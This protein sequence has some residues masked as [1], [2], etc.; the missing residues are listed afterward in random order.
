MRICL[1]LLTLL[2][3]PFLLSAQEV[4]SG[5]INEYAAV[6]ELDSC[7]N[8]LTLDDAS[9]FQE[10]MPVLLMQMQGAT[11]STVNNAEFGRV[12]DP[13]GAGWYER[14]EIVSIAGNVVTLGNQLIH[15][16]DPAGKLQL[17]SIP[18]YE[19]AFVD[20]LLTA[21]PWNGQTGGVLILEVNNMLIL[22]SNIDVSGLGFRGGSADVIPENNCAFT[23]NANNYGYSPTDWRGAH[24]GE[25]IG[26]VPIHQSTG[27]GA[28]AN[29]GGGGNDHNSGG[30]GGSQI[31]MGGQGG[32]NREPTFFG[33]DGLYPG[34]GGKALSDL[35][36]RFFMGG[37]GGAGHENNN[38]STAGG[39]GGGIAII[40]AKEYLGNG[41]MVKANGID[42][43]DTAGDGAGGGGGAG[44]VVLL[45]ET[46]L[47]LHLEA[48]GGNGGFI[49]NGNANRCIGPGGGGGGGRIL[50]NLPLL[51]PIITFLPGTAGMSINSS[52]S[53]CPDGTNNAQNGAAGGFEILDSL[54]SGRQS[55]LQPAILDQPTAI[56]ACTDDS[57]GIAIEMQGLYLNFQWQ[58]DTGSGFAALVS[59]P[60]YSGTQ[61]PSLI[62][63]PI[64]E[65]FHNN[66]YR[67]FI[68][69]NC[70]MD[71]LIS[72]PIL[73]EV[74]PQPEPDFSF[75]INGNE[76]QFTNNSQNAT[77]YLW[78]FG[79]SQQTTEVNPL[80]TY[81][82]P[83]TY[84]VSLSATNACGTE[85]I[86]IP[87]VL[88]EMSAPTAAFTAN[89]TA[90]CLPL[91]VQFTSQSTG[92]PTGY[93]WLFP[94]GS[95]A[96]SSME[97]PIVT[98]NNTGTY[99]ATLIVT[100]AQG[101]DSLILTDFIEVNDL[102]SGAFSY[103]LNALQANFTN[104]SVNA[105]S[106]QWLFG[107]SQEST[108]ESPSHTYTM[109][110][111]YEVTLLAT[112]ACGTSTQVQTI[113]IGMAPQAAFTAAPE[114]GCVPRAIL[115]TNTSTGTFDSQTWSFPGGD[116]ATSTAAS[117]MVTYNT[118]GLY[119]VTLEL[120]SP[121]GPTTLTQTEAIEILPVPQPD[122]NF[123][124]D[125][126]TVTFNNLSVD[127]TF[128]SWNFGDDNTSNQTNPTYTYTQPGTYEVSL[129]AQNAYCGVSSSQTIF[130]TTSTEELISGGWQVF[131]NP[132][133]NELKLEYNY[134]HFNCQLYTLQGQLVREGSFIGQGL[135]PTTTLP[136]GVYVLRMFGETE[137]V[138]KVVR[139]ARE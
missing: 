15:P 20:A 47:G 53:G 86:D 85:T 56:T 101:V 54:L 28:Q 26:I 44:T 96:F 107:D 55:A 79:D 106:Y 105:D 83:G 92:V 22:D 125:G 130:L 5:I 39:R 120:S 67:L 43:N 9:V 136:A 134:G 49:N 109:P 7:T 137:V 63:N 66:R 12:L 32:E 127:A 73:L 75:V 128:F 117:V 14:N 17:I 133:E 29:G 57:L 60:P 36:E 89:P 23:T 121:L 84:M 138:V 62:I 103:T 45:A 37:G 97:N 35:D 124:V 118:I 119:D 99:D 33:C 64:P 87:I 122:F 82:G 95:P 59:A 50:S 111:V 80:H 108:Q 18:T 98:Y 13:K 10:G 40:I 110:G 69:S 94:G 48:N 104:N 30:G 81:D 31:G 102:P 46:A 58:I 42:G 34:L 126:L 8:T 88:E 21:Q 72:Q 77:T 16:Y 3:C 1:Y 74:I 4:I 25:G 76:V 132:F 139:G 19:D 70:S 131:P 51:V 27:R 100:N 11:L 52:D 112:N 91:E 123:T 41:Y 68:L 24:K 78:D 61:S 116:P 6:S 114:G 93:T 71:T 129:N 113:Q 65:N 135:L 2:F 115:F 90:G 38:V